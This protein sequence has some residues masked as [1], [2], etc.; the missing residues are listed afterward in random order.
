LAAWRPFYLEV[1]EFPAEQRK[2]EVRRRIMKSPLS[3]DIC[4]VSVY[5]DMGFILLE[6][7]VELLS[8]ATLERFFKLL[9]SEVSFQG[10]LFLDTGSV[11]S[12]FE[13][14][15]FAATEYCP[16]RRQVIV[17]RV[18]DENA[19][20]MGGYAGHAGLFGTAEGVFDLISMLTGAR[21]ASSGRLVQQK[22]L[23][24]FFSRQCIP[25][26][27]TWALG[28]DTPSSSGSSAGDFFSER[29]VGHLGFTGTSL[30]IDLDR[31]VVVILLTNRIHPNR[32]NDKIKLFR[33][34]LHDA[35]MRELI[36]T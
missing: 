14:E 18:H 19:F 36:E 10:E 9:L 2:A 8:G 31:D 30:W 11:P 26:G 25:E 17:G 1:A 33:P 5:S 16:W 7:I 22:T 28:W 15:R 35:V 21:K 12:E 24:H 32:G 20:A 13:Q 34:L 23:E 29:S 4:T 3:H 27:S 6:W